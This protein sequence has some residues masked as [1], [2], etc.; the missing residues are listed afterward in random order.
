[1]WFDV[2]TYKKFYFLN[3]KANLQYINYI[4]FFFLLLVYLLPEGLYT[5][6]KFIYNK[7]RDHKIIKME[8]KQ[9]ELEQLIDG[10]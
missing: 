3:Q 6:P 2:Y 8:K 1:M 9:I 5:I 4:C 7:I 10:V